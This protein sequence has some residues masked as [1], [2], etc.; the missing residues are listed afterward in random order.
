M[1]TT[2]RKNRNAAVNKPDAVKG[3]QSGGNSVAVS[4]GKGR[5]KK[6]TSKAATGPAT[7]S[8]SWVST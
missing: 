3:K 5:V 7:N 4:G 6:S 8:D 1:P 2:R